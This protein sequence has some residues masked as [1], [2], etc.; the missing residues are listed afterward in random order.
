MKSV[1]PRDPV[2][3]E[4]VFGYVQELKQHDLEQRQIPRP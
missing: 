1:D 2:D 4:V 3:K